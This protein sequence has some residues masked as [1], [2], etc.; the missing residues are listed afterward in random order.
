MTAAA[1][2]SGRPVSCAPFGWDMHTKFSSN[3]GESFPEGAS[4]GHTGFTGTSLWIDPASETAVIFLSN[5][6]HPDGK[7]NVTRLRGQIA[8]LAA[9]S[10]PAGG[11]QKLEEMMWCRF[12]TGTKCKSSRILSA[13]IRDRHR[14]LAVRARGKP[15]RNRP[16][17]TGTHESI[18]LTLS[19]NGG[20][21]EC[22][23]C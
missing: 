13:G 4:F 1:S 14:S 19:L 22:A 15:S 12:F 2:G 23:F 10:L 17:E 18:S 7:G 5:R 8:T 9:A 6:V 3:R 16:V 11:D 20:D 21:R